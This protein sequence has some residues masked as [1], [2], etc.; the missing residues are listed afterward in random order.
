M[1]RLYTHTAFFFKK[2]KALRDFQIM[3]K[4]SFVGSFVSGLRAEKKQEGNVD[5]IYTVY[6]HGIP[7]SGKKY[8]VAFHF[9]LVLEDVCF[10]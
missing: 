2:Q 7:L 9:D 8:D 5:I 6:F 4:I 10:F 1:C 3:I